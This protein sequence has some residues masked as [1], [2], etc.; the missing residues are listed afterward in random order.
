VALFAGGR[1]RAALATADAALYT[2]QDPRWVRMSMTT[3][4][5][6]HAMTE[7]TGQRVLIVGGYGTTANVPLNSA[8]IFTLSTRTFAATGTMHIA[9]ADHALATLSDGRVLVTGGLTPSGAGLN[10]VDVASTEIFNPANGTFSDGPLMTVPRFNHS[11][12]TLNDGRVLV[13]GGNNKRSA[14]VFTPGNNTFTA[15][16]DMFTIHGN[17]HVALKLPNGRV[18]ISGGDNATLQ[19]T[20]VV[21]QFDPVANV[22][23]SVGNMTTARMLHFAVL[24]DDGKVLIGGGRGTGGSDLSSVEIYDPATNVSTRIADMPGASS[25]QAAALVRAPAAR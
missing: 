5:I 6:E 25:D 11:A 21:E 17:G 13:L 8:E 12:I 14:E 7:I 19:P 1:A 24:L 22:F 9:R 2:G 4:R 18:L 20:S 23:T 3:A 15:I 16:V 10:T